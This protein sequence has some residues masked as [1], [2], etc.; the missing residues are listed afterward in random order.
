MSSGPGHPTSIA[1]TSPRRRRG[2]PARRSVE[3]SVPRIRAEH[4]GELEPL[5]AVDGDDLNGVGVRFEAARALLVLGVTVGLRDTP[6]EPVRQRG[7]ADT[8]GHGSLV[9]E[10]GD[11]A[12]VG[13]ETLAVGACEHPG[14]H[15][16]PEA[17]RLEEG[18]HS[19]LAQATSPVVQGEMELLPLGLPAVRDVGGGPSDE[20][21]QRHERRP[22]ARRGALER[23]Q[24][25][26]PLASGIGEEDGARSPDDGGHADGLKRVPHDAG[27]PVGAHQ[28]RDPAGVQRRS[29]LLGPVIPAADHLGSG[30]EQF[31]RHSGDILGDELA[32]V[33]RRDLALAGPRH[34][35]GRRHE[36]CG[37]AT[38]LP[39]AA[40]PAGA[41]HS[42]GRG[43][44]CGMRSRPDRARHPEQRV[45]G[46][47][48]IAVA[49]PVDVERPLI[50]HELLRA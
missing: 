49:A 9:K 18:C 23:F 37:R 47:Q 4:D 11:V 22:V 8:V 30:L 15:G 24:Q 20:L 50:L 31:D 42:P 16:L 27:L 36:G 12:Q 17:H 43:G 44:R 5:A 38:E 14:W 26:Q 25:A 32:C 34:Q 1:L 21:C 40:R 45:E 48:E 10:L 33:A 19:L 13:H 39:P 28:H 3:I 46:G 35:D 41:R 29:A 7:R 6:T 2:T